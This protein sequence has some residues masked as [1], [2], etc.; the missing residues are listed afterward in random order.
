MP[1]S[2]GSRLISRAIYNVYITEYIMFRT[3]TAICTQIYGCRINSTLYL[4]ETKLIFV[5]KIYLSCHVSHIRTFVCIE[6]INVI[7]I[8]RSDFTYLV[9]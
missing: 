2:A 3:Y 7:E 9:F 1:S 8:C 4:F 6:G 5:R